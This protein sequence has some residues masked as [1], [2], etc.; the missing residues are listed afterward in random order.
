MLHPSEKRINYCH[1]NVD[2]SHQHGAEEKPDT[3]KNAYCTKSFMSSSQTGRTLYGMRL[4][5]SGDFGGE[6]GGD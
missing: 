6:G 4:W 3:K 1:S 5:D 2:E